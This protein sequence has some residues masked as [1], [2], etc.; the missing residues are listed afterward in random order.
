M[1]KLS[2]RKVGK[3]EQ[4]RHTHSVVSSTVL[5]RRRHIDEYHGLVRLFSRI[6]YRDE[7]FQLSNLTNSQHVVLGNGIPDNGIN[8]L[9]VLE[10]FSGVKGTNQKH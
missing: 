3:Q 6:H 5:Q 8:V 4:I 2:A 10:Q 1:E 9:G 7:E